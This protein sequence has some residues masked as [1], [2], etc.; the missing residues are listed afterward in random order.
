MEFKELLIV[1][2][3]EVR[4][5]LLHLLINPITKLFYLLLRLRF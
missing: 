1:L 4:L 5:L 2:L 3:L